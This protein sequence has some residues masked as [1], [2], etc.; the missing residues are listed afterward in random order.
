[1]THALVDFD[2]FASI[3]GDRTP[4]RIDDSPKD[5]HRAVLSLHTPQTPDPVEH[6]EG[7]SDL[8]S[9]DAMDEGTMRSELMNIASELGKDSPTTGGHPTG[10]TRAKRGVMTPLRFS[11][12]TANSNGAAPAG[13]GEAQ[14]GSPSGASGLKINPLSPFKRMSKSHRKTRSLAAN[15]RLWQEVKGDLNVPDRVQS[16]KS[17]ESITAGRSSWK[18]QSGEPS[19][20]PP[21]IVGQSEDA[22]D[23]QNLWMTMGSSNAND[24]DILAPP[25]TAS[26]IKDT[27]S[28]YIPM[29][30]K[31]RPTSLLTEK[32]GAVA[33]SPWDHNPAPWQVDIPERSE[34]LMSVRLCQFLDKYHK[35]ECLLDLA[36]LVGYSRQQLARFAAGE[37]SASILLPQGARCELADCH[38]PVVE[39]LLDCGESFVA[40]RGY[41]H[42][43]P[44]NPHDRREVL[45]VE[46]QRQFMVVTRGTTVEQGKTNFST[47]MR[48]PQTVALRDDRSATVIASFFHAMMELE[49]RTFTLLDTVTTETPFC[50]VIFGGHAFGAAMALQAA[51]M[52]ALTRLDQRVA[53]FLTS[54]PRIGMEN[55]RS[56]VNGQP[57][58]K[59]MRIEYGSTT[60]LHPQRCSGPTRHAGHTLRISA[61]SRQQKFKVT[62][63]KFDDGQKEDSLAASSAGLGALLFMKREKDITDYV[64][65]MEK[66]DTW[67]K[68]YFQEDG[69]GVLG[70]D[71]ESRFVV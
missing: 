59:V 66:V 40:V 14:P 55:F 28:L 24:K 12:K 43:G 64:F 11:T 45:I 15:T 26:S 37:D 25:S 36:S 44:S 61:E 60:H 56:V 71:D 70:K 58:L 63:Y 23:L 7:R 46:C 62:A 52:Y 22:V 27:E 19:T 13:S 30:A 47:T 50:D 2:P 21:P 6:R 57:N 9:E 31:P 4:P 39:A 1:M 38:R 34:M 51:Y 54:C 69:T 5:S 33:S 16:H 49:E 53:A 3:A 32:D 10:G 42:S 17:N 35:K 41:F 20:G 48:N 29:L 65:A 18:I 67:V 8:R 68:D